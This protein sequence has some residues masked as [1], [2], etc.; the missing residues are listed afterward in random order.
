MSSKTVPKFR[1]YLSEPELYL[2]SSLLDKYRNELNHS[3]IELSLAN[4]ALRAIQKT[5]I[6]ASTG[7]TPSYI[8]PPKLSIEE[9]LGL[10]PSEFPAIE[11]K[12]NT[13]VK[14]L[15]DAEK[16][17]LMSPVERAEYWIQFNR[18]NFGM[19]PSQQELDQLEHLRSNS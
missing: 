6:N 18:D 16:L 7:T 9:K 17:E 5:Y 4:T 14:T 1:P 15:S 19:E 11:R 12:P 8:Q 3:E 13:G 10:T 2:I